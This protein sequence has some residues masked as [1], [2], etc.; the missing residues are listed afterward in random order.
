MART[1]LRKDGYSRGET[2]G[3]AMLGLSLLVPAVLLLLKTL[4]G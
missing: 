1:N 2:E 3:D 4:F